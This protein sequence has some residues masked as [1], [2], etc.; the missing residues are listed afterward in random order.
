ML[1]AV[2]LKKV[3]IFFQFANYA[4]RRTVSTLCYGLS[5]LLANTFQL[6]ILLRAPVLTTAAILIIILIALALFLE[7][8][9][10][11][12][13]LCIACREQN[14]NI[15][16]DKNS[17]KRDQPSIEAQSSN[18]GDSSDEAANNNYELL[19]EAGRIPERLSNRATVGIIF[20]A[21]INILLSGV[22]LG[23]SEKQYCAAWTNNTSN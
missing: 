23:L 7:L 5:L 10:G 17:K 9:F 6:K 2:T 20:I 8:I 11:I 4:F 14:D 19:R 16:S 12:M 13:L 21:V 18:E 22:G 15:T 3:F 1:I